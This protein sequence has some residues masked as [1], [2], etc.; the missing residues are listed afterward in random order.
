MT[1]YEDA[2]ADYEFQLF[3]DGYNQAIDDVEAIIGERVFWRS[4]TLLKFVGI[5]RPK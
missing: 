3:A 2:K 1:S 5:F 4:A